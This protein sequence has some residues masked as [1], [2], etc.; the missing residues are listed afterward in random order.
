[1]A[2]DLEQIR[3]D[4]A[5]WH[6]R[7]R[8]ADGAEWEA[9]SDWLAE[10]VR[11]GEAYDIVEAADI[12]IE[13]LLSAVSF[14]EAANDD[15]DAD[16]ESERP[17]P[18]RRRV[19]GGLFVAASLVAGL[20]AWQTF[21][22]DRYLVRTAGGEQRTIA[23][24]AGTRIVLNGGTTM[25]FDRKDPRFASLVEGEALFHVRHDKAQ[26]F[27]LHVGEDRIRDAGTIFNVVKTAEATRVAVSEGKVVYNPDAENVSLGAG[28]ALVDPA[29]GTEL[30]VEPVALD[31]VGGWRRGRLVYAGA[32]LSRVAADLERSLG[33]AISVDRAIAGRAVSG[34]IVL[35]GKG[36]LQIERLEHALDVS[37]I[38]GPAG[39]TMKPASGARR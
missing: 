17:A 26:P 25:R 27:T 21:S 37:I 35:D 11:H 4:A 31:T 1:M 24:D 23:L 29:T 6:V 18:H 39:W 33:V 9:F 5:A 34:S 32:P 22:T 3:A 12:A 30:R 15:G 7:L 14:R 2:R 8:D 10:D 38:A 20:F 28:Q 19:V 16:I 36:P 13:P